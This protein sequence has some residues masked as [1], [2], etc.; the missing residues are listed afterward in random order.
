MP[1]IYVFM[2]ILGGASSLSTKMKRWGLTQHPC[3]TPKSVWNHSKNHH[4]F[5]H[6]HCTIVL[7]KIVLMNQ[8]NWVLKLVF[9]NAAI[10]R[11]YQKCHSLKRR[12]PS[13]FFIIS[14]SYKADRVMGIQLSISSLAV[15]SPLWINVMMPR[16]G[17]NRF[18]YWVKLSYSGLWRV[19]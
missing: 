19:L 7:L 13:W 12:H 5:F 17:S 11:F 9:F 15:S 14:M 10:M 4:P 16:E 8:I 3:L 2:S 18:S 1:L 6:S